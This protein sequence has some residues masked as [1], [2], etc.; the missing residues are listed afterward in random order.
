MNLLRSV[1]LWSLVLSSLTGASRSAEFRWVESLGESVEL[2]YGD[3]PVLRYMCA[4]HDGSSPEAHEQTMKP[5]HHVFSPDGVTLLTKG[6]GGLYPHHRGLFFGFMKTGYGDGLTADTWHC[7][8]GAY[9]QHAEVLRSD[10]DARSAS[11]TLRIV[12]HGLEGAPMASETRK[13]SV[14]LLDGGRL[15]GGTQIGFESTV[16]PISDGPL[17]FDG[18]PQHAGFQFRAAQEVA[19]VSAKQTHYIRTDGVGAAGEARNWDPAAPDSAA[20]LECVDRPWN[21]MAFVV[22]GKRYTAAYLDHPQN[23]KP[24]RW[25]ERDYGRF[26][27]Y[28]VARATKQAPLRVKYR[29]VVVEGELSVADCE[30][31]SEAFL[32]GEPAEA[33]GASAQAAPSETSIPSPK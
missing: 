12:W 19:D 2:R 17:T 11:H 16:A 6:P 20:S 21:A 32:R 18:D 31:L 33:T 30:R 26:G 25:S 8:E 23:P 7:V 13:L 22:G 5:Y 10:A 1:A 28:F 15:E 14:G 3:R 4:T 29:V 27:S 9:Q 24:S